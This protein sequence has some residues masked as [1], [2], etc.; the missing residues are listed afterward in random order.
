MKGFTMNSYMSIGKDYIQN[1]SKEEKDI[2][3]SI[4][5]TLS[6]IDGKSSESEI[7]FIEEIA[8]DINFKLKPSHFCIDE[9]F[10][11]YKASN[12]TDRRLSLEITKY[13]LAL[14]YTDNSFSDKEGKFICKITEALNL[15]PQKV[16]EISSWIIDRIIWLEQ[17]YLI[18]EENGK[19]K[20][21]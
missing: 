11:I 21:S 9:N 8:R 13:M 16:S 1:I 14:S 18:F 17:A 6:A 2:F 10:C 19:Q 15:E 12:I 3:L 5:C 4:L 7:E 20:A